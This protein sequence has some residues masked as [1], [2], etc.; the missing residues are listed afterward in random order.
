MRHRRQLIGLL[1]TCLLASA[2]GTASVGAGS[3]VSVR[4]AGSTVTV[5]LDAGGYTMVE[6]SDGQT[7][8]HMDE[9]FGCLRDPG[10][11]E[12]PGR[13]FL[14]ALPPG[15]QVT[16]V[17][18]ETLDYESVPGHHQIAPVGLPVSDPEQAKRATAEWEAERERAYAS[19]DPYPGEV[20]IYLGQGQ[21][22]RYTYARVAFQPFTYRPR[23]G[24]LRFHP[25][26]VVTI[27]YRLPQP[28]S[29]AWREVER[30]RDDRVMDDVIA[31]HLVNFDQAWAWY[32]SVSP[33]GLGGSRE[34]GSS[35]EMGAN[36]LTVPASLY[37]Y[38]I[39]VE[40]DAMATAVDPFK[41][42]KETLGHTVRVV[43]LEWVHANYSGGD[44]A[45]EV[46]NFLH[47]KYPSSE[48]GIRYVLLVGDVRVIPRRLV[49][50]SNPHKEWGLQS[51]MVQ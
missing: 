46:W 7:H 26:L 43:T 1:I 29:P 5:R 40:N 32:D 21:W 19:D 30:L 38:V 9:D 8:I 14:I 6:G 4:E 34:L 39:I 23:S 18:F 25:T 41:T 47:R 22:R 15:A 48:W 16:G 24:A 51:G 12:L 33:R 31:D 20:G 42:W 13:A 2:F 37:D 50:Y 3:A 44:A 36:S 10:E 35:I 11:P 27:E 28:G 49:F 17:H 45:E